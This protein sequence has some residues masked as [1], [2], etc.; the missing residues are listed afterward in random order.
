MTAQGSPL[1]RLHRALASRNLLLALAT[2]A[3][4]PR[5]PLR[6]HDRIQARLREARRLEFERANHSGV[7]VE[8]IAE[9]AGVPLEHVRHV[10]GA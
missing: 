4:L 2:A 7:T 9:V 10:L 6:V 8:Q 3:E 5:V 1:T